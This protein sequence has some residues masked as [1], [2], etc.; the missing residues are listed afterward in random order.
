[1]QAARGSGA[2]P[3]AAVRSSNSSPCGLLPMRPASPTEGTAVPLPAPKPSIDTCNACGKLFPRIAMRLCTQCSMVE[4][5]RFRLVR[6]FIAEHDGAA[7]GDI[8][9]GTGVSGA[10]VRR[11]MDGGRL[12]EV[13][14]GMG[15]CT[16]GGV[17]ERC[18]HC[19]SKLSSTFRRMEQTMQQ[20]AAERD[21]SGGGP[22]FGSDARGSGPGEMGRTSYVRRIRRIG[23][24]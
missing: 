15:S 9:R 20:D 24:P 7:V 14:S 11:F 5:H 2:G 12:V 21:A 19:R 3:E 6:D 18:R 22:R 10:D 16:C 4:E 23:E 17:G 13:T 1:M 8:S